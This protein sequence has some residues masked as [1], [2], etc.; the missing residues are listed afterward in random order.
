MLQV[1]SWRQV[2]DISDFFVR[3]AAR[4]IFFFRPPFFPSFT[5]LHLLAFF[6]SVSKSLFPFPDR[7][8]LGVVVRCLG[9]AMAYRA[10]GYAA[11]EHPR[12]LL[13]LQPPPPSVLLYRL[14]TFLNMCPTCRTN[15]HCPESLAFLLRPS[16]LYACLCVCLLTEWGFCVERRPPEWEQGTDWR[17]S[18]HVLTH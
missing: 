9:G 5:F 17:L 6:C 15:T 11:K 8:R 2:S 14:Y 16:V 13:S 7:W 12:C 18:L 1:G 4:P 3:S 10:E